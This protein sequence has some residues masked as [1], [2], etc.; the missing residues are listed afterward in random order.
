MRTTL[1][2][3]TAEC[4]SLDQGLEKSLKSNV[5]VLVLKQ[6]LFKQ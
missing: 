6:A 2:Q 3:P 1:T 4:K 5:K